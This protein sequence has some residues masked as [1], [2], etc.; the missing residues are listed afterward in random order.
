MAENMVLKVDTGA[1][2]IDLQ[3]A[4]GKKIGEFDFNPSDSNIFKR[5]ENVVEFFN[6]ITFSEDLTEAQQIEEINKICDSINEQFDYLFGYKVG[7]SIFGTCGP[8]T[9]V[10]SGDFFFES[11]LD[12]IGNLIEK[13]TKQRVEKKLAKVRKATAKYKK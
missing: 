4:K 12:G 3:D 5:Y 2:T 6:N 11:V 10:S 1:I 8:L 9:V 13:I 7:S